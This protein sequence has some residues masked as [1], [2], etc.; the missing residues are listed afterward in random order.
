VK[1][2]KG[3][4]AFIALVLAG[5]LVLVLPGQ[6][7]AWRNT[8]SYPVTLD[9][10]N[11]NCRY[12][13]SYNIQNIDYVT[14]Q[15]WDSS[16]S[17]WNIYFS[18]GY[19]T[20]WAPAV[21]YKI[22]NNGIWGNNDYD[23]THPDICAYWEGHEEEWQAVYIAWQFWDQS[24]GCWEIETCRI[25]IDYSGGGLGMISSINYGKASDN[26]YDDSILPAIDCNWNVFLAWE[27]YRHGTAEIYFDHSIDGYTWYHDTFW[28]ETNGIDRIADANELE[29]NSMDPCIA[30]EDVGGF[31]PN[32]EQVCVLWEEYDSGTSQIWQ[33]TIFWGPA[34]NYSSFYQSCCQVNNGMTQNTELDPDIEDFYDEFLYV[35]SDD[36]DGNWEIYEGKTWFNV[37]ANPVSWFTRRVTNDMDDDEHPAIDLSV[38]NSGG[39]PTKEILISWDTDRSGNGD[40]YACRGIQ[41]LGAADTLYCS[42]QGLSDSRVS[43]T[44]NLDDFSDITTYNGVGYCVWEQAANPWDILYTRDP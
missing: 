2:I 17:N 10:S 37:T 35:W 6:I 18:W 14:W 15:Q 40:I 3:R 22:T 34:G 20:T 1:K 24:R 42:G 9:N 7:A 19:D 39:Q 43:F 41:N 33:H 26:D 27:D 23:N 12:P 30:V 28:S 13:A 4:Y 8:G 16:N 32:F 44:N 31:N 25:I 21:P 38:N 11:T 36:R 29:A 5:I